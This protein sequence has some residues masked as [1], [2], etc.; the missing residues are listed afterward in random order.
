MKR[1]VIL[2]LIFIA[3]P[4]VSAPDGQQL[5]YETKAV[6]I[7]VPVRV[8][9]GEAFVENLT[10]DDFEVFEDGKPQRIEAVYLIKKTS[11]ERRQENKKFSPETE[12][13][14]Y[15][16]FEMADYDA[17]IRDALGYFVRN[18]LLPGDNLAFITPLKTYRMKTESF[19]VIPREKILDQLLEIL[20]RDVLIGNAEYRD[21]LEDLVG[22]AKVIGS[23]ISS[24]NPDSPNPAGRLDPFSTSSGVVEGPSL[25][26]QLT[27]YSN[28]LEKLQNLRS[29]E[30]DKLLSFATYLKEQEGQ[31]AVFLFYQREFIPKVDPKILSTYASLYQDRPN[32]I[33]AVS[34]L[35]DL[36]QRDSPLNVDFVKQAY[37][38]AS[39]AIHFLFISTPRQQIPGILM[40]E[41]SEDIYAPF[42]EMARATGGFAET[43]ANPLSLMRKAVEASENYYLLYYSPQG[44]K[45]DGK[46]RTIQVKVKSGEYRV[47]HRAGYI[48]D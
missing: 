37:S 4:L 7:E 21:A 41:K 46:F 47:S 48:A 29:V 1:I 5:T 3:V 26:E 15:L 45:T 36:Y 18:V 34:D 20:R 33:Q 9:K 40:D 14:F 11:I 2:F 43:S 27:R 44:Y 35:F 28:L 30:Q 23:A 16:F 13:Y 39:T 17:K 25:D 8:F 6:N 31:K 22:T 12:R 10:I 38:D 32:V 19:S 24:F 42:M